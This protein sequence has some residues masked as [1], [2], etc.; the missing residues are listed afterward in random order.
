MLVFFALPETLKSRKDVAQAAGQEADNVS[1]TQ[2]RPALSRT[3]TREQVHEKSKKWLKIVRMLFLDPL[4]IVL[5]LRFPAVFFTVYYASVTFGS[6]YV[7]NVSIQYTF[8]RSP[9]KFSTLIVGLLYLPNSIGYILASLVGGR[10]MDR[11]MKREAKKANRVAED[12]KLIYRPEDRMR[13][14][15]WLGALLYPVALIWYGWTAEKGVYFIVPVCSSFT[16]PPGDHDDARY[17][18]TD[19]PFLQ[20]IANFFFGVGSM[21]IFAMATTMLTEFMPRKSSNGVAVNN[22]M[23]NIFSCVGGVVGAPL[24]QA[25][26]NGWLFTILGL[27]TLASCLVIWAMKRYGPRWREN[28][29]KN[30]P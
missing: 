8:E 26:G 29:D 23:R 13:E 6:L 7:L 11:I 20:M 28:M 14:N 4:K 12:G 15:A 17:I 25:I 27:W 21:L 3:S 1:E 5:Y 22:L 9:Y 30:M 16:I 19:R 24:L 18:L 2:S 10:W